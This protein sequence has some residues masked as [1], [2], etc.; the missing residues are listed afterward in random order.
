MNVED[1]RYVT[2]DLQEESARIAL[3]RYSLLTSPGRAATLRSLIQANG[4][5]GG[6]PRCYLA[7][8]YSHRDEPM[9]NYRY[10]TA[11][12]VTA[13][14]TAL[15][16]M[17][18]SPIVHDHPV[19][20]AASMKTDY[21]TWSVHC[22]DMVL[23][24]D[25]VL[26]LMMSGWRESVGTKAEIEIAQTAGMP[27]FMLPYPLSNHMTHRGEDVPLSEETVKEVTGHGL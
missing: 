13:K 4:G 9:M 2:L 24:C 12:A 25:A 8:P 22:I 6:R 27:V 14:L 3:H 23:R 7:Q 10:T 26:V 1:S 21:E 17:I 16:F 18:Y 20:R 19:S 11:L 15:G 5:V